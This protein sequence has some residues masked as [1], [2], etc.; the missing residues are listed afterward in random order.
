[1]MESFLTFFS[2]L[3]PNVRLAIFLMCSLR[4]WESEPHPSL[5][6]IFYITNVYV[7]ECIAG[8]VHVFLY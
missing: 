2:Y 8:D 4:F 5:K 6:R 7:L 3:I 1:M